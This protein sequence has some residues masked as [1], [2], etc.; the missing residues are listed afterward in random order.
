MI[1]STKS[2]Q[3][4][5]SL[6]Q[7]ISNFEGESVEFINLLVSSE[8]PINQ[9]FQRELQERI[10]AVIDSPQWQQKHP[11]DRPNFNLSAFLSLKLQGMTY[12]AIG[13]H[14]GVSQGYAASHWTREFQP[15]L[16]ELFLDLW[17][18]L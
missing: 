6:N 7:K 17:Q 1:L 8:N 16:R 4:P 13:Q 12:E 10:Q 18:E 14:L 2:R 3:S 15:I 11:R 9:Q 5:I